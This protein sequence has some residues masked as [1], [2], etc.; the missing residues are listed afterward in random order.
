MTKGHHFYMQGFKVNI[1][2]SEWSIK[3]GK[4]SDYPNLKYN[5]GYAGVVS[6]RL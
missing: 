2:G 4:E 5:D 1:L 6:G 3:F